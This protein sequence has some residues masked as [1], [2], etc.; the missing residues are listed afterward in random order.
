M[1][2]LHAWYGDLSGADRIV[3]QLVS[4]G[5]GDGRPVGKH[6][7][8]GDVYDGR[9]QGLTDKRRCLSVHHRVCPGYAGSHVPCIT[10]DQGQLNNYKCMS[11]WY[12]C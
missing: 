9:G 11:T 7:G 5:V 4:E 2:K 8:V 3:T 10:R 1:V 12:V 6:P